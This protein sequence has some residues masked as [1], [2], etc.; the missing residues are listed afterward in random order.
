[1]NS[2]I[3][4]IVM[5]PIETYQSLSFVLGVL[6]AYDNLENIMYSNYISVACN[7]TSSFQNMKLK[8]TEAMWEDYR[9]MGIAEMDLYHIKNIGKKECVDFLKERID[10]GNYLLFYSVDEYFLSY[11]KE[12]RKVHNKHDTYVYG[13]SEKDLYVMAY[14]DLKLQ[15]FCVPTD[16]IVHG[17]Y[18]TMNRSEDSS[19]C[20]FR[21]RGDVNIQIKYDVTVEKLN[22]Y[23][24]G[25]NINGKIYG[26]DTYEVILKCIDASIELCSQGCQSNIDLRVFRMLWEHKKMINKTLKKLF[27]DISAF[28][29]IFKEYAELEQQAQLVFYL[30]MKYNMTRQKKILVNVKNKIINLKQLEK[31]ILGQAVLIAN[32]NH[33]DLIGGKTE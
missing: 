13:Y 28:E 32:S 33:Y 5:P 8:Y 27:G 1:M 2:K 18:A 24:Q 11:T 6:L 12:Y 29:T 15:L 17:L 19:F 10:Q 9:K 7:N 3:L 30:V 16:E 23:I 4:P 20:T 14:K 31:R 21:P 22:E 25:G 26:I